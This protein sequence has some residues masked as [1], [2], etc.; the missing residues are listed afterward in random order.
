[1]HKIVKT[2]NAK[3]Q[4]L[5]EFVLSFL[6]LIPVILLV[7]DVS[8]ILYAIQFNESACN[9]ACRLGSSGDPRLTAIRARESLEQTNDSNT[10]ELLGGNHLP[11]KLRLVKADTTVNQAQL[12]AALPYGGQV[13]GTV[14]VITEVTVRPLILQWLF[15]GRTLLTFQCRQEFPSTYIVPNVFQNADELPLVPEK[16]NVATLH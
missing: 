7:I 6:L 4:S 13:L 14:N 8:L 2:R 5:I 3:G 12:Q 15:G 11:F 9:E 1:M 16:L 10:D